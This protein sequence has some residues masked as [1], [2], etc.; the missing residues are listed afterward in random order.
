MLVVLGRSR[1]VL[2]LSRVTSLDL[3]G[4][5]SHKAGV[6]VDCVLAVHTMF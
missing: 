5:V 6:F 3:V 4:D 1:L 2:G